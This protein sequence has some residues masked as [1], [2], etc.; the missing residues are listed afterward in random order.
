[1]EEW[2]DDSNSKYIS[3][4]RQLWSIDDGS[5]TTTGSDAKKFQDFLG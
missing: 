5:M 3:T 2:L 4:I 1:M